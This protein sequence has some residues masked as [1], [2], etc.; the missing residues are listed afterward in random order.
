MIPMHSTGHGKV[1]DNHDTTH[2]LSRNTPS[3]S[4]HDDDEP[5]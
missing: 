3:R 1:K 2:Q 4:S 5:W